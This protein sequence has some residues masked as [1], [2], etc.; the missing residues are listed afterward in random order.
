MK[1]LIAL[2]TVAIAAFAAQAE[3]SSYFYW[4]IAG[5]PDAL[6]FDYAK[7]WTT[8]AGGKYLDFTVDVPDGGSFTANAFEKDSI[9][10]G[11]GEGAIVGLE[12][13]F[14][15]LGSKY[16]VELY[17]YGDDG[18]EKV[19]KLGSEVSGTA[20]ADYVYTDM[21]T[22]G[23]GTP[24]TFSGFVAIPEPTSGLLLL[25]GVAGLSL[26]RKRMA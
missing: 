11:S 26:R 14:D 6:N 17:R 20:I 22:A 2:M 10:H 1:K 7:I 21:A 13:G 24:F 9:M 3:Y 19:G 8:G 12:G 4:D 5:V 25:L 16:L 23:D 15:Y 18:D